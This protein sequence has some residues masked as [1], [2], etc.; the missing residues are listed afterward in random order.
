MANSSV[1]WSFTYNANGMRTSRTNGTTTYQYVYTGTKLTQMTVGS[2]VLY[3]TYDAAGNP[4]T[5]TLNGVTFVYT[6][7]PQGDVTAIYTPSGA[8][9]CYYFYDAWG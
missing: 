5:V 6:T 3:F 2:N 8:L 7:N 9:V 1:T 4:A